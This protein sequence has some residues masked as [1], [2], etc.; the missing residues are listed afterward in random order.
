MTPAVLNPKNGEV[1]NKILVVRGLVTNAVF[2]KNIE[3]ENKIPACSDL[4]KKADYD[5]KILEIEGK[6]FRTSDIRDAK[7]KQ[8][9]E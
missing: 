4:L 1:R 9:K 2:K 5:V 6:Y 7:I 8:E 3:V